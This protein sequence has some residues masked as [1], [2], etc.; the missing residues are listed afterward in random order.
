[1]ARRSDTATRPNTRA[2]AASKGSAWA[3][4]PGLVGA[5]SSETRLPPR[6][7]VISS[8]RAA[9]DRVRACSCSLATWRLMPGAVRAPCPD[10]CPGLR[11]SLRQRLPPR[12]SAAEECTDQGSLRPRRGR[13]SRRSRATTRIGPCGRATRPAHPVRGRALRQGHRDARGPAHSSRCDLPDR[14][15]G[16]HRGSVTGADAVDASDHVTGHRRLGPSVVLVARVRWLS[17]D[18]QRPP[19]REDVEKRRA[20][21]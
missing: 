8:P 15:A 2:A 10:L 19:T 21:R 17:V 18:P 11:A 7:I 3:V 16:N 14:W 5:R 20:C 6:V 9:V 4:R 1:M 13:T 12:A